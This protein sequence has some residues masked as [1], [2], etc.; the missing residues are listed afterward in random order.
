L[1]PG[2]GAGTET[3]PTLARRAGE[4]RGANLDR[5]RQARTLEQQLDQ[6]LQAFQP[7]SVL[8]NA[9]TTG[10]GTAT[11]ADFGAIRAAVEQFLE[12]LRR[13]QEA[14]A[15]LVLETVNTDIGAGD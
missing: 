15:Q 4:L 3:L 7:P 13:Y 14:E 5:I 6:A 1:P 11:V 8:S 10:A 2:Q 9:S 12:D